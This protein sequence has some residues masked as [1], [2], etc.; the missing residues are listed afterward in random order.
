VAEAAARRKD[1]LESTALVV[2][3]ASRLGNVYKVQSRQKE[4]LETLQI[5]LTAAE[6]LRAAEPTRTTHVRQVMKI[7][8]DR[9]DALRSQFAAEGMRPDLSLREYQQSLVLAERLSAADPADYSTRVAVYFARAQVADTWREIEPARALPLLR[10]LEQMGDE[11]RR[12]DPSNFQVQWISALLTYVYADSVRR[13]GDL[14]AALPYY[15]VAITR[16]AAM[17]ES[18]RGR[19][20]SFRDIMKTHAERGE[21]RLALGDLRGATADATACRSFLPPLELQAARPLDLR[22]SAYCLELNGDVAARN[23]KRAEAVTHY[24]AALAR[25]AEFQRR[26]MES[27]FL[28]GRRESA[29]RRRA[30]NAA[31]SVVASR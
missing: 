23:G 29:E 17:R 4:C 25:W 5:A 28:R 9:G 20:I 3:A 24:H 15:D 22:D 19:K 12:E 30:E 21:V 11:L 8:E 13:T 14:R 18:D 26:G 7:R 31:A 1:S 6:R 2:R 16:I 10:D 27:A